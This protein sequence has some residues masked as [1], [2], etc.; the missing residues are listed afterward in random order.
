MATTAPAPTGVQADRNLMK[1]VGFIGLIWASAGSIIG[2]G[3]LF[4]SLHAIQ[5]AGTAA[6]VSWLIGAAGLMVLVREFNT[7]TD[8]EEAP[9]AQ[10]L[11]A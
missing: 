4:G 2:S 6:I 9:E 7:S 1:Q 3:W 11:S 8:H 10:R 5:A